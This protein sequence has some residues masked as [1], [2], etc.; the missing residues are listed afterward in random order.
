M[1]IVPAIQILYII[2]VTFIKLSVLTFDRRLGVRNVTPRFI[3]AVRLS[4]SL[5]ALYGIIWTIL[6]FTQCMPFEAYWMQFAPEWVATHN[7]KCLDEG[8]L[9]N[10]YPH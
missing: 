6:V 8:A 1:Q 2:G 4:I 7:Y 3:W 10:L 9:H 5:V